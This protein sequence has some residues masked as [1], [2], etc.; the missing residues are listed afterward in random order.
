MTDLFVTFLVSTLFGVVGSLAHKWTLERKLSQLEFD[1]YSLVERVN[2]EVKRRA[3]AAGKR[4]REFEDDAL[5]AA[6]TSK[7]PDPA[8]PWWAQYA[9]KSNGA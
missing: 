4:A 6:K 7:Q 1:L 9:N 2:T 8:L 3:S 5:A